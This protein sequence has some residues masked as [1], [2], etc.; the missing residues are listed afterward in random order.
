M[1]EYFTQRG[2]ECFAEAVNNILTDEPTTS[3][4]TAI[5]RMAIAHDIFLSDIERMKIM[6]CLCAIA[7]DATRDRILGARS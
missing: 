2:Y 6:T 5:G 1:T 3:V 4:H 7:T